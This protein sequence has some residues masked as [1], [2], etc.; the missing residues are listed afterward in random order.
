MFPTVTTQITTMGIRHL[1]RMIAIRCNHDAIKKTHLSEFAGKQIAI[2]TSIYLYRFIG[3]DKLLEHFYLLISLF[4]HYEI[5][6]LFVFDGTAPQEKQELLKERRENKHRAEEKYKEIEKQLTTMEDRDDRQDLELELVKLKKDFVRVKDTDINKIKNLLTHCGASYI[7]APGEA[8]VLCAQLI[9]TGRVYACLSEDMDLFAYGCSR[10][11]RHIS[12]LKH[13]VLL[14]DLRTILHQLHMT[15]DEF[16][17]VLVLSGTDYNK[18]ETTNLKDSMALFYQYKHTEVPTFYE[19]LRL[20]TEY[21]KNYDALKTAYDMFDVAKNIDDN[22][23][24][25]MAIENGKKNDAEIEKI[26]E[27]DGFIFIK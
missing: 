25:T 12:L 23:I 2:D 10:I 17:Q 22:F 19:W 21:I 18:D 7:E 16:R 20:N 13:T 26:M 4:R 14:Y 27:E 24:K 6:P 11:L 8:D 3:E 9:H 1:N 5:M 15:M